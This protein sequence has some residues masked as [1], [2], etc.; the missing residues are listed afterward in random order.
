MSYEII[1]FR[2]IPNVIAKK[3]LKE[4]TEKISSYDIIPELIRS[5]LEYLDNVSKC[6]DKAVEDMYNTLKS[7]KLKD[8][9]IS[10]ILNILP[11]SLDE[12]RTLLTFEETVPEDSVLNK[13]LEFINQNCQQP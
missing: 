4:Y 5:T 1:E 10:M 6:D 2:D 3:I 11:R 12:L 8:I 13:I 9:T 7:F